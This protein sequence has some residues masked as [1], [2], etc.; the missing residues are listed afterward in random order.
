MSMRKADK[1]EMRRRNAIIGRLLE[2]V[3]TSRGIS[4]AECAA[5]IGTTRQRYSAIERGES[6]I[7]AVELEMLMDFLRISPEEIRPGAAEQQ[8]MVR[9]I[10]VVMTP[11]ETVHMILEVSP[12]VPGEPDSR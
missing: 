7:A 11:G 10:P 5:A 2:Q 4:M 8:R 1:D 3:R 12:G 6:F 9:K